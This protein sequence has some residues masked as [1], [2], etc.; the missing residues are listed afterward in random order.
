[1]LSESDLT[2]SVA[3]CHQF[4]TWLQVLVVA[5]VSQAVVL[6]LAAYQ[7]ETTFRDWTGIGNSKL[8]CDTVFGTQVSAACGWSAQHWGTTSTVGV[9]VAPST[10]N[11][12]TSQLGFLC[13][14]GPLVRLNTSLTARVALL[15]PGLLISVPIHELLCLHSATGQQCWSF[16]AAS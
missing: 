7:D 5:K 8:V 3:A 4:P 2:S 9:Q 14:W 13:G 16:A 6:S 11:M 1:M 10:V 15:G 12:S